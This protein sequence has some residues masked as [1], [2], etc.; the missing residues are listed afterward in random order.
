MLV[1]DGKESVLVGGWDRFGEVH[2]ETACVTCDYPSCL[3][4]FVLELRSPFSLAMVMFR[5]ELSSISPRIC[6]RHDNH[7]RSLICLPNVLDGE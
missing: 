2:L 3:V 7:M 4:F 6:I 1:S 5:T